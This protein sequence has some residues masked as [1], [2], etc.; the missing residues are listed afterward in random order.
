MTAIQT[1]P[2]NHYSYSDLPIPSRH[3]LLESP[4]VPDLPLWW[5]VLL[6]YVQLLQQDQCAASHKQLSLT[7][8]CD[9][10]LTHDYT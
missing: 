1:Q 3:L 7:H 5:A 4:K 6:L 8:C 2:A 9:A 10:N